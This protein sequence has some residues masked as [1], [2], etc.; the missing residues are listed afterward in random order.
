MDLEMPDHLVQQDVERQPQVQAGADGLINGAQGG[1]LVGAVL[2]LL[3]QPHA[4]QRIADHLADG[5]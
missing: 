2:G 4:V 1:Q 3:V 5:R